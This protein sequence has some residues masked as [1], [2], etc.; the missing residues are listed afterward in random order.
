MRVRE[1]RRCWVAQFVRNSRNKIQ[2]KLHSFRLH[3]PR[4]GFCMLLGDKIFAI[5]FYEIAKPY[6]GYSP[7]KLPNDVNGGLIVN[8]FLGPILIGGA[9]GD[10]GHHKIYFE[11]GRIF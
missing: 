5:G 1:K 8:T 7:S 11:L 4:K 2:L 10:T 9:W 3:P 6:G